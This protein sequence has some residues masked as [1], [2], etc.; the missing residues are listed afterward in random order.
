MWAAPI[1]PKI[2]IFWW[3]LLHNSIPTSWNRSNNHIPVN[4]ECKICDFGMVT[5]IHALFLCLIIKKLWKVS[6][7][8]HCISRASHGTLLNLVLWVKEL[9]IVEEL[10]L[11]LLCTWESW[12][13]R[14]AIVHK[15]DYRL[16]ITSFSRTE[17]ALLE[18]KRCQ[19]LILSLVSPGL[20]SPAMGPV[21]Q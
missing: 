3:K 8:S 2:K 5:S 1:P 13:F 9:F 18:F 10:H 11:F 14:N 12:N 20:S 17:A 21:L 4:L 19:A 15:P 6:I 16:D 7:F